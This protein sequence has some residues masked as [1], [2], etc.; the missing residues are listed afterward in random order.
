MAVE[1]WLTR[2]LQGARNIIDLSSNFLPLPGCDDGTLYTV[3]ME[4]QPQDATRIH[5]D[6]NHLL[7][8]VFPSIGIS[9]WGN[10]LVLKWNKEQGMMDIRTREIPALRKKLEIFFQSYVTDNINAPLE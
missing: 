6:R 5:Y 1:R 10:L 7:K 3:V 4:T 9:W 8:N 2:N